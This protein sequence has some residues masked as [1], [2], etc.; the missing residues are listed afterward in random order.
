MGTAS[1]MTS[2]VDVL[3]LT[4]PG[5]SSIPAVDA[6]P[7]AD[8]VARGPPHRGH[9]L[10]GSASAGHRD[11]AELRQRRRRRHGAVGSTNS[12]IHLIAMARQARRRAVARATSRAASEKVPVLCNLQP[13]G[14]YLME[15]FYYAGG[16]WRL[17]KRL[18]EQLD[19]SCIR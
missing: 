12:L 19:L 10:G 5:A 3:G 13:S 6:D 8:G 17:L 2:L 1:T 18:A 15:D 7:L 4:L 16:L 11:G 9:G 14:A